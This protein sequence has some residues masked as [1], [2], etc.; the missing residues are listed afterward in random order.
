MAEYYNETDIFLSPSRSEA[1]GNAVVEAAYSGNAI[2]ASKVGGQASLEIEGAYWFENCNLDNLCAQLEQA[3]AQF[4][5]PFMVSQREKAANHVREKYS[6]LKW[7]DAVLHVVS[8][9][10]S[11]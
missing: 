3:I 7:C 8:E 9:V 6:L 10:A 11:S 5:Q 1:F 2:V 4:K